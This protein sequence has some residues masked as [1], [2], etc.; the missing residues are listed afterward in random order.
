M[1]YHTKEVSLISKRLGVIVRTLRV[2]MGISR[3]SFSK[4]TGISLSSL[5]NLE[6][7]TSSSMKIFIRSMLALSNM[8]WIETILP[9]HTKKTDPNH[10]VGRQKR[11]DVPEEKNRRAALRHY[12]MTFDAYKAL[13]YSQGGLCG[14][15]G[16]SKVLGLCD[17]DTHL[18]HDHKT[19][20]ARGILC[21]NCNAA[22]G[23]I[24]ERKETALGLVEYI[25]THSA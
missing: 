2:S 8:A 4:I 12:R 18:D 11:T 7:G 6:S 16:C 17:T 21:S 13:F 14:N 20:M 19:G 9:E 23:F 1:K 10:R 24:K 25:K 5:R 3:F 15:R 22:L